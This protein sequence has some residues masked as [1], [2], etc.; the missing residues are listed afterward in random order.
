MVPVV[1]FAVGGVL[2]GGSWSMRGQGASKVAFGLVAALGL[3][4]L[5]AGVL[6][7]LPKGTFS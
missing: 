1:L 2:I 4:A 7:L 5:A 3:V 6:W